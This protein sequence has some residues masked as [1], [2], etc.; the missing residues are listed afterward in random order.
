MLLQDKSVR[1]IALC[2]IFAS[3]SIIFSTFEALLPIQ[4]FIPL[5]GIKLGIS[6]IVVL[7]VLFYIGTKEA[8]L[9]LLCRC[10]VTALIFGSLPS[11]LFSVCGG[12]LS[13]TSAVIIKKT[14]VGSLSFVG[15]SIIGASLHNTGQILVSCLMLGTFSVFY[16]LPPLLF[17]SVMCGG[18][19]G[20][21]LCFLPNV[22]KKERKTEI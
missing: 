20:T 17:A 8:V 9:V 13:L 5:P 12:V 15:V 3:L 10:V 4:A 18:I 16:Y 7:Y 11:F 1:M 22:T 6:N 2:G 19:T 14:C 21:I